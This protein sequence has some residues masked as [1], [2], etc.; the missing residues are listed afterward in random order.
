MALNVR[1]VALVIA[2][3]VVMLAVGGSA[4]ARAASNGML[5]VELLDEFCGERD[6]FPSAHGVVLIRPDGSGARQLAPERAGDPQ[7]SSDGRLLAVTVN[8]G[9]DQR[10][11]VGRADGRHLRYLTPEGSRIAGMDWAPARHELIVAVYRRAPD[12]EVQAGPTRLVRVRADGTQRRVVAL[13]HDPVWSPDARWIAFLKDEDDYSRLWV[14]R[15]DGSGQRAL[16]RHRVVWQIERW[17]SSGRRVIVTQSASGD[18]DSGWSA[19]DVRAGN[20]I[21]VSR[22]PRWLRSPDGRLRASASDEYQGSGVF[23]SRSDGSHRRQI[24]GPAQRWH[25]DEYRIGDWQPLAS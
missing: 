21:P 12:S 2:S 6:C 17:S 11:A 5:A 23:V 1:G 15:A 13:G 4:V 14:M 7:F 8:R 19:V 20:S 3:A 10:V 16:L 22:Q 9:K 25:V 24:M 18:G